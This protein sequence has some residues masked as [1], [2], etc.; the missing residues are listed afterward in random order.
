MKRPNRL[1]LMCPLSTT[2]YPDI[3]GGVW[4]DRSR[5]VRCRKPLAI[6]GIFTEDYWLQQRSSSNLE[7]RL[8]RYRSR[9]VQAYLALCFPGPQSQVPRKHEVPVLVHCL[10][11]SFPMKRGRF[12]ERDID[13]IVDGKGG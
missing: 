6:V 5:T 10:E 3:R 13:E 4:I 11:E 1:C 9:R 12:R 8:K 2:K 7:D